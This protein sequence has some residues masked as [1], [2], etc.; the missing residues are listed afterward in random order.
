MIDFYFN[1]AKLSDYGCIVSNINSSFSDSSPIGNIEL[2]TI[3]SHSTQ[4]NKII[5]SEYDDV[6]SA[7]FDIC[8]NPGIYKTPQEMIFTDAE[9]SLFARWLNQKKY[10]KFQPIYESG[11][12]SDIFFYGTFNS[13]SSVIISDNTVGLTL[14]FTSNSPFG[15]INEKEFV[16]ELTSDSKTFTLY[17]DSDEI[18]EIRPSLFQIKCK[19]N[20]DLQIKN[21]R[22]K[23]ITVINNCLNEEIIT[24]DCENRIIQSSKSHPTIYNDFNYYYPKIINTMEDRYNIFTVTLPCEIIVKYEPIRKVGIV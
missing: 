8:K 10:C 12:Y 13:I 20:G 6:I 23:K 5:N 18:G 3:K 16:T 17:D 4:K 7:S 22:D 24:L 15:Y 9:I 14:S 1:G 11:L 19:A 2:E 21:N